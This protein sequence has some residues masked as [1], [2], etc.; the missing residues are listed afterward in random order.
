MAGDR[1]VVRVRIEGVHGTLRALGALPKEANDQIRA[2]SLRLAQG[3]AAEVKAEGMADAAPQS[4]LVART[5][6]AGKDRVPVITAGGMRK[7]GRNKTPAYKLLFGSI[8]GMT[9]PSGWFNRSKY[10]GATGL[11]F[12]RHHGGT[13]GYWFFPIVEDAAP[14]ISREWNAAADE[15]VRSFS[16][17]A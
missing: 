6:R 2:A 15:V 7:L 5:V 17:G 9:N 12:H 13:R 3:L 1:L 10:E 16:Q 8:F 14:R 11:Q 4:H